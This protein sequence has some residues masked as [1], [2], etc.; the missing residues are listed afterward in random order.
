M[1]EASNLAEQI[2]SAL[3]EK[4]CK[5]TFSNRDSYIGIQIPNYT[6]CIL[7]LEEK[8]TWS[9]FHSTHHGVLQLKF[10]AIYLSLEAAVVK[11]KTWLATRKDLIPSVVQEILERSKKIQE[12]QQQEAIRINSKSKQQKILISLQKEFPEFKQFIQSDTIPYFTIN[13]PNLNALDVRKV[14]KA[15]MSAGINPSTKDTNND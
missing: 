10:R 14:I 7:I 13:F 8:V 3:H 15:L 9:G 5:A 12:Y 2:V 1:K 4:G 11:K 6:E